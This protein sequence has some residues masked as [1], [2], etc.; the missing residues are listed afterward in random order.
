MFKK[1]RSGASS[2]STLDYYKIDEN[3]LNTTN[4][5]NTTDDSQTWFWN[6]STNK[7]DSDSEKEANH[8]DDRD[9]ENID[10][11]YSKTKEKTSS[12]VFKQELKWNKE[13]ERSLCRGYES[14]SRSTRWRKKNLAQELEKEGSKSYNIKTL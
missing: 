9:T 3:K 4:T 11:K 5:S 10:E 1:R 12:E 14:G 8:R 13:G 6:K 7:S 2:F